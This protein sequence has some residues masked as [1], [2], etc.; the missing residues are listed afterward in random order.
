MFATLPFVKRQDYAR[1]PVVWNVASCPDTGTYC[2][3]PFCAWRAGCLQRFR[4]AV[5]MLQMPGALP[6]TWYLITNKYEKSL[7]VSY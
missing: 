7:T 1:A 4:L 2:S 3:W 5:G 6:F